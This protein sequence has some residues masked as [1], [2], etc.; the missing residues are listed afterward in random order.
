MKILIDSANLPSEAVVENAIATAKQLVLTVKGFSWS[1]SMDE[2][3]G[4]YKMGPR[5]YAYAKTAERIGKQYENV[6]PRWFNPIDFAK[7]MAMIEQLQT[8]K[9]QLEQ[10]HEAIDDTLMAF[11][12]DAMTYTKQVHDSLK[13]ANGVDQSYDTPLAELDEFQARA[14]SE[15]AE[16]DTDKA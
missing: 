7:A 5:R 14:S 9:A 10:A 4:S 16:A 6:M 12:I 8:L 15:D 1:L 11:R 13:L 3:A 2:R